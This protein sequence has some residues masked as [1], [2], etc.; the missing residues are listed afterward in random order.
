ME[1]RHVKAAGRAAKACR[2]LGRSA[3]SIQLL[4]KVSEDSAGFDRKSSAV[5]FQ[6]HHE[7]FEKRS[8]TLCGCT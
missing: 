6:P 1:P 4:T 8:E 2:A 7:Q 3:H 5:A